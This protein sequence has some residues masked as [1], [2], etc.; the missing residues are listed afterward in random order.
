LNKTL[1]EIHRKRVSRLQ[2]HGNRHVEE[3]TT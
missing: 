1:Q 3:W 2:P